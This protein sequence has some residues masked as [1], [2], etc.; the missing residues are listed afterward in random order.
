[1]Q[2]KKCFE[3]KN[4]TLC[5]RSLRRSLYNIWPLT[6]TNSLTDPEVLRNLLITFLSDMGLFHLL[7]V[8]MHS[9]GGLVD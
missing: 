9:D 4:L 5:N 3:Y 7:L 8:A 2:T 6:N 1:M